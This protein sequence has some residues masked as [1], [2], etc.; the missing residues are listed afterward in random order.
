MPS[1]GARR[2]GVSCLQTE[3]GAGGFRWLLPPPLLLWLPP[4]GPG[5]ET[6]ERG[7][8]RGGETSDMCQHTW[9]AHPLSPRGY[10]PEQV[11]R[12]Y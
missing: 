12:R 1:W 11:K 9:G 5:A 10:L 2:I 3:P 7:H 8:L 6:F 4:R